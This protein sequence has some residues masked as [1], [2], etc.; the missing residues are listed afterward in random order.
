MPRSKTFSPSLVDDRRG[1]LAKGGGPCVDK[2][3]GVGPGIQ[4]PSSQR[5]AGNIASGARRGP[6][7]RRCRTQRVDTGAPPRTGRSNVAVHGVQ[8]TRRS[9]PSAARWRPWRP[10]VRCQCL[11]LTSTTMAGSQNVT[12]ESGNRPAVPATCHHSLELSSGESSPSSRLGLP[13]HESPHCPACSAPLP[14]SSSAVLASQC[15]KL[16]PLSRKSGSP[17]TS[18][19]MK[20]RPTAPS[21][22]PF[23]LNQSTTRDITVHYETRDLTAIEGEDYIPVGTP[24]SSPQAPRPPRFSWTSWWT[25]TWR[26][27]NNSASC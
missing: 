11:A 13:C 27:T 17:S 20:P 6:A 21:S 4:R 19:P 24:S 22:F 18:V 14:C 10:T 25:T 9:Q 5:A 3:V 8:N 2:H 23:V 16:H 1:P 7:E 15:R 26:R 12:A